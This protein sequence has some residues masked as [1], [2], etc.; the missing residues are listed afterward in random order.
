[1]A[2]PGRWWSEW[3]LGRHWRIVIEHVSIDTV[4]VIR[5]EKRLLG[6]ERW[7]ARQCN[8]SHCNR[9]CITNLLPM[10]EVIPEDNNNN[11][12]FLS[13]TVCGS[14]ELNMHE[15]GLIISFCPDSTVDQLAW[16]GARDVDD[17]RLGLLQIL[18]FWLIGLTNIHIVILFAGLWT[19]FVGDRGGVYVYPCIN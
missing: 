15:Q 14:Y 12:S 2:Y 11:Y 4:Q 16:M 5:I 17:L 10:P 6:H 7:I 1:M 19:T 9:I 3:V 8:N 18:L 13:Q